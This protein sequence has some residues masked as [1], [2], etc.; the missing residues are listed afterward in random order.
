LGKLVE[1]AGS[2]FRNRPG[3]TD[4]YHVKPYHPTTIPT[5]SGP[6][7]YYGTFYKNK[8]TKESYCHA[9]SFPGLKK[10]GYFCPYVKAPAAEASCETSFAAAGRRISAM[11]G[12]RACLKAKPVLI[13]RQ[14]ARSFLRGATRFPK[15]QKDAVNTFHTVPCA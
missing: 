1:E 8:Y 2:E 11:I 4:I 10:H 3:R 9:G 15:S 7:R 13:P 14:T 12:M 6:L 5:I